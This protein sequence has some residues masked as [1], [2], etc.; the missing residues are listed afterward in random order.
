MGVPVALDHL[1]GYRG[2]GQ[3]Q[4]FTD[5]LLDLGSDVCKR[6]YGARDL[7]DPQVLRRHLQ[8]DQIAPGLFVPDGY[9]EPESD[10]LGMHAVGP[11]DLYGMLELASATL[12][13]LA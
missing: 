2:G 12:Q 13:N 5:L 7:A 3:S 8:A 6:T 11:S 9:L 4:P 1:R 10:R